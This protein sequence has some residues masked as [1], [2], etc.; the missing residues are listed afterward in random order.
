MFFTWSSSATNTTIVSK[1]DTP[2]SSVTLSVKVYIPI[3]NAAAFTI[4]GYVIGFGRKSGSNETVV[5]PLI[6][7]HTRL[8]WDFEVPLGKD[9]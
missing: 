7:E 2:D 4:N 9:P 8:S 1:L 5:G 3:F 6:C